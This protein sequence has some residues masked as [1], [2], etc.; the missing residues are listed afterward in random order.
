[1]DLMPSQ[2]DSNLIVSCPLA[3]SHLFLAAFSEEVCLH[4]TDKDKTMNKFKVYVP[5]LSLLICFCV[6]SPSL[7]NA[8]T[9]APQNLQLCRVNERDSAASWAS[10]GGDINNRFDEQPGSPTLDSPYQNV[11]GVV[12]NNYDNARRGAYPE[13]KLSPLTVNAA[14]GFQKIARWEVDGQIYGQPLYV[15]GLILPDGLPHNVVFVTTQKNGVYAF[16][17]EF[18]GRVWYKSLGP[19][20]A[21][22]ASGTHHKNIYPWIGITSTP[23][24]DLISSTIY[25]VTHNKWDRDKYTFELHALELQTGAEKFG[26]PVE[27]NATIPCLHSNYDCRDH[28]MVFD[29]RMHF[30]RP[31]LLLSR[32]ILYIAFGGQGDKDFYHGWLMSYGA[33]TLRQLAVFNTTPSGGRGG[34]WQAGRGVAA[35]T[36][37]NGD[38]YFMTGNGEVN[39]SERD[40]GVSFVHLDANLNLVDWFTPSNH[41]CLNQEYADL[42]LGS[43]GPLLFSRPDVV[44][45][46]M[47]G[48]GKEGYLYLFDTR[49]LT[50]FIDRKIG[51]ALPEWFGVPCHSVAKSGGTDTHHIH[52]GLVLWDKE[53]DG[54]NL[55][56]YLMGENDPLKVFSIKDNREIVTPPLA[57]SAYRAPAGMPG[58]TLSVSFSP[59]EPENGLVWASVPL[60]EDASE[61]IVEGRLLAFQAFP[62]GRFVNLL[63]DS[64]MVPSR[65]SVGLYAKFCPPTIVDGK[66]FVASFGDPNYRDP[67]PVK[68]PG[69]TGD[70]DDCR[71]PG[72]LNMYGLRLSTR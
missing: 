18:F 40:L 12:T 51:T 1:M 42:D 56:V 25:V 44:G 30:N 60:K 66:V 34:I 68:E 5:L 64:Q 65:D 36:G 53:N 54:T 33:K 37:G 3:M 16:D 69:C 19:P 10:G 14:S 71:R 11:Y 6:L 13:L 35:D 27:I 17:T 24:I 22:D 39:F 21:W 61:K 26:G 72:F 55:L 28:K 59:T 57:I 50:R 63:W 47:L 32:N 52:G 2:D 70:K 49:N 8:R 20:V 43:S 29:P 58:G 45:L 62:R 15:H 67:N 31:G 7:L 38:I 41:A 46:L 48:G 9:S 23:V 4:Q